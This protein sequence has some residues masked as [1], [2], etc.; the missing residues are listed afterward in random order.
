MSI[1]SHQSCPHVRS[2]SK[3][4]TSFS[5][6]D[7]HSETLFPFK[8]IEMLFEFHRSSFRPV[9]EQIMDHTSVTPLQTAMGAG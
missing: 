2:N 8:D 5:T 1:S 3:L 4:F 9:N 7:E 6:I